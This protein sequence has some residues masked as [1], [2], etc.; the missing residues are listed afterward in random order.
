MNEDKYRRKLMDLEQKYKELYA[1]FE[2]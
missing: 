1:D 2:K